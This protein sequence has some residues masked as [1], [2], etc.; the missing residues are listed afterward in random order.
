MGYANI[1]A[2]LTGAAD[3]LPV[4]SAA[5][6][7]GADANGVVK[8]LE[9]LPVSAHDLWADALEIV[10]F[11]DSSIQAAQAKLRTEIGD[12]ARR[13]ARKYDLAVT[14]GR[15]GRRIELVQG[16]ET[17]WLA[18]GR[19]APLADLAVIGGSLVENEGFWGGIAA[20]ALLATRLPL[21]V[22]RSERPVLGGRAAIFWDGSAAAGRAVKAAVPLL[23]RASHVTVFQD[24]I[25]LSP[26]ER[27]AGDPTRLSDELF[28][29]GVA[30]VSIVDL[31]DENEGRVLIEAAQADRARLIV[32][33]GY[34][35]SRFGEALLGGTTRTLV[36]ASWNVNHFMAH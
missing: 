29:R 2:I 16:L 36:Q 23:S 4:L 14:A 10:T 28:R 34:G 26:E 30:K 6:Q 22:V 7:L 3:D 31:T 15:A 11:S 32:S 12:L 9:Q 20:E 8:V 25:G 18:L 17:A 27:D 33:G 21:L 1:I 13:V 35:H 24:Q 5:A 19:E